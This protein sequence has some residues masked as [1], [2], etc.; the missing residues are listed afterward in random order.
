VFGVISSVAILGFIYFR[1]RF[2]SRNK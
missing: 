1:N 2:G